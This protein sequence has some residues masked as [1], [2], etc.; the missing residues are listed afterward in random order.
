MNNLMACRALDRGVGQCL[1][2]ALFGSS[3]GEKQVPDRP[4]TRSLKV[5]TSQTPEY[6]RLSG[7]HGMH[8]G[9]LQEGRTSAMKR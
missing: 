4:K 8:P 5:D 2:N 6:M 7:A 9:A 1:F 3:R